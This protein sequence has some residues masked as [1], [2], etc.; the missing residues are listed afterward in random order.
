MVTQELEA[1]GGR[2]RVTVGGALHELATNAAKHGAL[3]SPQGRVEVSWAA[4]A[5]EAGWLRL[6]WR[7]HEGPPVAPPARSGF[8]SLLLEQT[9]QGQ[10]RGELRRDWDPAG[11]RC[12]IGLP[13]DCFAV[14]GVSEPP[15]EPVHAAGKL[16]SLAAGA[17]V[18]VVEDEA[19]TA[20]A[21]EQVLRDAGYKVLGP[22]AR[23]QEALDLIRATPPEAAV[24]DVNLFGQPVLPVAEALSRMGVPFLFCTGY[25]TIDGL[26][27]RLRQAPV[28]AEPV[29]PEHLIEMI[30][31][32]L[33]SAGAPAAGMA[34]A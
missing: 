13:G 1:Y 27:E 14:T 26:S 15:A 7:E 22:A 5:A 33:R 10:L 20:L 8:G 30:G 6:C 4:D 23:V 21:L 25:T 32:L 11:L 18:L 17:L 19:L 29:A 31:R 9:I 2:G 12:R 3:S 28:L 24:L 16:A 34:S